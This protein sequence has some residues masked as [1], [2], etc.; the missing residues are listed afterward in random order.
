MRKRIV[1]FIT[2]LALS[3]MMLAGCGDKNKTNN[4]VTSSATEEPDGDAT[5]G[6][7]VNEDDSDYDESDR[8]DEDGDG[9]V[10]DVVD[11]A[12]DAVDDVV[13][14]KHN[15]NTQAYADRVAD[16]AGQARA[17]DHAGR[18]SLELPVGAR[19][20]LCAVNIDRRH[21]T[22]SCRQ[23]AGDQISGNL[24]PLHIHTLKL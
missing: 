22:G 9:V 16:T 3:T 21:H 19:R 12:A 20:R 7:V 2:T 1:M 10:G 8:V 23:N 17:A 5:E 14:D 15:E 4:S 13:D 24:D 6:P 18:D 11:D